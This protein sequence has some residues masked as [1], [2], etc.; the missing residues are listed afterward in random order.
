M[1]NPNF[2]KAESENDEAEVS[3]AD[4]GVSTDAAAEKPKI[5]QAKRKM[6]TKDGNKAK[7]IKSDQLTVE[8]INELKETEDLYHSNLFRMQIDETLKEVKL[9]NKQKEFIDKW[10]STFRKFL[11]KLPAE[12]LTG[13]MKQPNFPL[14]FKLMEDE[15]KFQMSYQPPKTIAVYGSHS[16]GT[17]IGCKSLVDVYLTMPNE[18]LKRHDY[19]SQTVIHKKALYLLHIANKL[20][21]KGTL[22][23][24]I[25]IVNFK[26][27]PLK[28]VLTIEAEDFNI[29][30]NA[31]PSEN[32]FKLNRFVPQT[33]NVKFKTGEESVAPT[34]HYNFE[35]LFDATIE[36]TQKVLA[37]EIGSHENVRN[38]VKLLKIWLHQRQFDLGFHPF[39][40]FIVSCYVVHLL[41]IRKVYPTMSCY[42][43]IRLFWNHF[44]HSKLDQAGISLCQEKNLP[45][46]PTIQD[47][48]R[49][50]DLVLV[51]STG[52]CN[53]L[54]MLSVDLYKRVR[55]ECLS[56]IQMLDN[57]A[58]NSFH[59]LF[60]TDVPFYVQ[61][62][63]VAA[64]KL[65]E[66][67]YQS[68][69]DRHGS[70]GDKIN[71]HNL[72]YPHLRKMVLDV[73]R[74]GLSD[75]VS[76]VVPISQNDSNELIIGLI[77]NPENTFNIV[78]KGPQSN[79]PEAE[80]FRK[81]W[82]GKAEIRRFKDG[83]ITESVLW[84][85]ATAPMGEKRLICQTIV[86]YLLKLHFHI[87]NDKI[88]YIAPQFDVTVR[89][90]FNDLNETNEERSLVA[91]KSFD[92]LSRELRALNDLPLE[93][94][95]VLGIDAV[96]RYADATPPI[97]NGS[98]S[99]SGF[100][101]KQLKGRFRAQKVLNGII[102]LS[103]S[104]KWPDELDAMRRIKGAFYIEIEK[105]MA[106]QF[107]D[108][109]VHV[110]SDSI[111][112][113]KNRI[114]FRLKIVHPKEVALAK[115]EISASNNLTKL[116]R[117]NEHSLRL[118]FDGTILPKLTS[119]L[120]G[121]HHQ[122]PCFGPTVAIAKRWLYS[123][124][125]DTFLWPDECTELIV[126]EMILKNIP[127]TPAL[128]PQTGFIRFL[129]QLANFNP[130][131]EMVV[132]NFND[133]IAEEQ[134]QVLE[135]KF[136]KA[137]KNFP[138]LFIVTSCDFQNYGIWS[139][140]APLINVLQRVKILAQHSISIIAENFTK[141]T[142]SIVNDLFTPSLV[143][144]DLIIHVKQEYVKRHG[145]VL[146]NF[147]TFKP[148]TYEDKP[149]PPADINFV[150]SFL[151]EIREAYDDFALFFYNPIG[152]SKIAML[153]K[154]SVAESREFSASHLNACKL[155]KAR[156]RVNTEAILKDIKIIG[157][158]LISSIEML[159]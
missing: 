125:I 144:Y 117:T 138:P 42:Q 16:L 103:P 154:P 140:R 143:G 31:I 46:Q 83:S 45:S 29:A 32:F 25:K 12:D 148:L 73:L 101:N 112:A 11:Q 111:E 119:A 87:I 63:Q 118:E 136:Q 1:R 5:V 61:Y 134:L 151:N 27:D 65:D 35:V 18:V 22:G 120:H 97:K 34:P 80:E 44:G 77:L 68:I 114:L 152:G 64:V 37:K 40:G 58:V 38:A 59:Q 69:V 74:R 2:A 156:L 131:T 53:I 23:G 127:T 116:Y 4:S 126:A 158:G 95:S 15:K 105:K 153:W 132:V 62:D 48:H 102:Q 28:P 122:F 60:L 67:F 41:R 121:L 92:E 109:T 98:V 139:S 94:V 24:N 106:A 137:R 104:G 66:K 107:P 49:F 159:N 81:F 71:F 113:M 13:L 30:I 56:A 91:I 130:E 145:V 9:K 141:L 78:E 39:N 6:K 36:K 14:K 20:E 47:F 17:N 147:S 108:T 54:S 82:G 50:Y 149:A 7:K 72:A 51:D 124:M 57:K 84:C 70:A 133:E 52:F 26:N 128:Q 115:E 110:T 93:I 75:R 85:P 86:K 90:I 123:Q 55:N 8:Q 88:N 142:T 43:I 100:I 79:A 33:N 89:N 76:S 135:S 96:F 146:Y 129:H 157:Q 21:A 150:E 3:D 155:D 99:K 19:L 10:V